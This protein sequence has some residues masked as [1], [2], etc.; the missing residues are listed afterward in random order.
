MEIHRI[1]SD[2]TVLSDPADVPGLGFLPVNAFVL[3]AQEP[4]VIDTGLGTP[5][6]DFVADLARASTQ[7]TCSG[8]G[9]PI[10]TEITPV[11]C[12]PCSTS[13]RERTW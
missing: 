9:S 1:N 4:V 6:K 7:R 2:V 13:L 10:L 11:V 3:H 5:D 12:G 8:S